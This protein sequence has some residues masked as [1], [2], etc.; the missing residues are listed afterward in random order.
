VAL[1]VVCSSPTLLLKTRVMT[2]PIIGESM[3][4]F[5][6]TL[7]S[8]RVGF[9]VVASEGIGALTK[10]SDAF[11]TKRVSDWATRYYFSNVVASM[12]KTRARVVP[13]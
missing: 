2:N 11:E 10:G 5:H 8:F 9:D 3:S 6:T 13:N 4:L 7:L 1:S 12:M